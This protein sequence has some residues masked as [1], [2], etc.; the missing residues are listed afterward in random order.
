MPKPPIL[1]PFHGA[2]NVMA[3]VSLTPL[4]V[5]TCSVAVAPELPAVTKKKR[6]RRKKPKPEEG[7]TSSDIL[8]AATASL[9]SPQKGGSATSTAN[10]V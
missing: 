2:M 10:T 4:P 5:P 7:K 6:V 8:A 9:F 3:P 1:A